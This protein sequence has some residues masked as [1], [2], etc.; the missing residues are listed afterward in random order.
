MD[1]QSRLEDVGALVA[2]AQ[3]AV[4]LEATRPRLACRRAAARPRCS[5]R[6]ASSPC[7]TGWAPN[8][9]IPI[10]TACARLPSCSTSCSSACAPHAAALG[11]EAELASVRALAEDAGATRQRV[12]AGEASHDDLVGL[13]GSLV[14]EFLVP[15]KTT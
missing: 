9:S 12:V 11:C 10:A 5:T 3:C 6:T 7:A 14:D 13:V 4:R 15:V 1:A 2:L 8:S